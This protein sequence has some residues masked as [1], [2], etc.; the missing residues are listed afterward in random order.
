MRLGG[1]TAS[2]LW[3]C[4]LCYCGQQDMFTLEQEQGG[5]FHLVSAGMTHSS[6]NDQVIGNH[7]LGN[8]YWPV[9]AACSAVVSIWG[10]F[11]DLRTSPCMVMTIRTGPWPYS[12]QQHSKTWR[13]LTLLSAGEEVGCKVSCGCEPASIVLSVQSLGLILQHHI[14]VLYHVTFTLWPVWKTPCWIIDIWCKGYFKVQGMLKNKTLDLED[15]FVQF[16]QYSCAYNPSSHIHAADT[17]E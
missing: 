10:D 12:E 16:V 8:G 15:V 13:E 2:V 1:K 3:T 7:E 17:A 14:S 6:K 5:R 4:Q 11:L 9:H